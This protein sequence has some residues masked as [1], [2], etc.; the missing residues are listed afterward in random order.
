MP[1]FNYCLHSDRFV[2]KKDLCIIPGKVY[3]YFLLTENFHR[4]AISPHLS[5]FFFSIQGNYYKFFFNFLAL[6]QSSHCHPQDDKI[7]I[8][9]FFFY[10]YAKS[11]IAQLYVMRVC[12]N[13][14]ISSCHGCCILTFNASTTMEML[15]MLVFLLLWLHYKAV[16]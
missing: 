12:T 2:D 5:P 9:F 3:I 16:Y 13:T 4:P 6:L 7:L 14:L 10:C 11:Y 15:Q 8:R 1:H